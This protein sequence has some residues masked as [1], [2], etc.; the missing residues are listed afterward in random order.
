MRVYDSLALVRGLWRAAVPMPVRRSI[1]PLTSRAVNELMLWGGRAGPVEAVDPSSPI[2]VSSL[3]GEVSGIA[4]AAHLT[5]DALQAAGREVVS[6]DIR[7]ILL[8]PEADHHLPGAANSTWILHCNPPEA[9]TVLTTFPRAQWEARQRIGYWAWELPK[10]PRRWIRMERLFHAI[11]VPSRFTQ[12]S[13]QGGSTSIHLMPHPVPLIRASPK[14][15]DDRFRFGGVQLLALADLKSTAARKNPLGAL[16]AFR[17]LFPEPQSEVRLIVKIQNAAEDPSAMARLASMAE[18]RA[19]VWLLTEAL[20]QDAFEALVWSADVLVSLHRA[21]GFGLP[22]AEALARGQPALATAWS[23]NLTYMEGRAELLVDYSLRP[24]PPGTPTYGG[25]GQ[26]W[27]EPDLRDAAAKL[28]RLVRD[29]DLRR[30]VGRAGQEQVAA[31][32][33]AWSPA[34]LAE[35]LRPHS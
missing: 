23:G 11:W 21:E 24:V 1:G 31:L 6:H 7:P 15:R 30:R 35:A 9:R 13:L 29:P 12:E 2:V 5:V 16:E 18:G 14:I 20:G 4:R 17:L 27:A 25:R 26:V 33:G 28:G 22:I 3:F 32:S 34:A 8:R 10:A 19:D